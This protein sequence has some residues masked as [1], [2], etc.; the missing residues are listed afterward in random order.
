MTLKD[1]VAIAAAIKRHFGVDMA[2]RNNAGTDWAI[3]LFVG[4]LTDHMAK[5]NPRFDRIKFWAA[6]GF[7]RRY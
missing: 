4:Q 6:C 5:D 7:S 3:R 2:W 1:Y